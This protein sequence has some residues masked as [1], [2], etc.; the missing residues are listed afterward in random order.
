MGSYLG[1]RREEKTAGFDHQFHRNRANAP[2]MVFLQ[3]EAPV[4]DSTEPQSGLLGRAA[5]LECA[6]DTDLIAG[7]RLGLD[8]VLDGMGQTL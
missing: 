3:P 1:N 8:L 2:R 7:G 6:G 5:G 4:L